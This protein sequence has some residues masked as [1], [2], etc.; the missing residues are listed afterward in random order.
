[1]PIFKRLHASL[2]RQEL[3][4]RFVIFTRLFRMPAVFS[5]KERLILILGI[6]FV[7]LGAGTIA[8][9]FYL[10][11]TIAI[12][13]RGGTVIEGVLGRPAFPN[14][15]L[16][17]TQADR[18]L[19]TLTYAGM[20][21]Y[22][23]DGKLANDLGQE[24]RVGE[25]GRIFEIT[26]K[27]NI[28]W[29]TGEPFEANDVVFT[30]HAI[31]NPAIRSPLYPQWLG[32][33]VEAVDTRTVRFTLPAPFAAFPHA[34]TLGILPAHVWEGTEPEKFS[35][36]EE[37]LRPVGLG[38]FAA[39]RFE[40]R[41]SGEIV[42]YTLEPN[43]SSPRQATLG[44]LI[45]KFFDTPEG[46]VAAFNTQEIDAVA[47]LDPQM[48]D[49]VRKGSGV[50]FIRAK[51]PRVVALYMNQSLSKALADK[52]V[53]QA[54]AYAMDKDIVLR[55]SLDTQ[56]T[57]VRLGGPL[58]QGV[59]GY[60]D[61]IPHIAFDQN[62]AKELLE[63]AGWKDT[64]GDGIREKEFGKEKKMEPLNLVIVTAIGSDLEGAA[65]KI[66]EQWKQVGIGVSVQTF[67]GNELR[68]AIQNRNYTIL[69]LGVDLAADPDIYTLF[70][71]S[72]KADPGRNF[73]AYENK[74][75]DKVLENLRAEQNPENRAT[76]AQE[77]QRMILEDLPA[78]FIGQRLYPYLL[79][80]RVRGVDFSFLATPQWRF[81]EVEKWFVQTKRVP[82]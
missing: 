64:N 53:R 61:N 56:D 28:L 71:S 33:T 79:D 18:D 17:S 15:V 77:A 38:P 16:A 5:F 82:K 80:N 46:A 22:D 76:L 43:P 29:P 10:T 74:N 6:F 20:L 42:S 39:K 57:M 60:T 78:I 3:S 8:A 68:T 52:S 40:R 41:R 81:S 63:A 24:M 51:L 21:R 69:L 1:M 47:G 50:N 26:L 44:K 59:L 37:N 54:L 62:H 32:I 75:L 65:N 7:V 67:S 27:D 58:P 13:A 34:L 23:R 72:Q 11:H 19:V 30:I 31:Q 2:K 35:L 48:L 4:R 36:A 9:Y 45:L 25:N 73:A 12:A 14:P 66:A 55:E 49:T 70:H